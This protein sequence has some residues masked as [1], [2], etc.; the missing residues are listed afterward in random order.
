MTLV[1]ERYACDGGNSDS[2]TLVIPADEK[3]ERRFEIACAITVGLPA[4][5]SA[6]AWHQMTV[7]VD[8]NQQW[9]RRVPTHNPGQFDGL[10]YRFSHSVPVGRSL[11]ITV[12]VAVGGARRRS[13]LIEAEQL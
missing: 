9:R 12:S 1:P 4:G 10:D 8:G 3:R 11:R 2:A 7:R 5:A 6:E 13:L